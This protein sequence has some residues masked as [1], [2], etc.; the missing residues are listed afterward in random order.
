MNDTP[1][2]T[3]D[4]ILYAQALQIAI[5]TADL[6]KPSFLTSYPNDTSIEKGLNQYHDL[7]LSI[8]RALRRK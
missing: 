3:N 4:Q 8:L 6:P 1:Q 7:A 5:L 2:I